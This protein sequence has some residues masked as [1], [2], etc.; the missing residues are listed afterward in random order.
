MSWFKKILPV[1]FFGTIVVLVAW[2]TP[3][4][5]SFTQASLFQLVEFFL[6]L[7]LFLTFLLNLY[8]KFFLKSLIFSVGSVILLILQGLAALNI[9]S[10]L[11]TTIAIFLITKSLK[12]PV[13]SSYQSKIPKLSRLSR[14]K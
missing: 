14:Q 3:P 5:K 9:I 10:A 11:L 1:I 8:F 2:L 4:P 13:S 12:K 7:L 6:P